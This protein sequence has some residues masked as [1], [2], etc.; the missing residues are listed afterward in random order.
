LELYTSKIDL[1]TC[2]ARWL[3]ARKTNGIRPMHSRWLGTLKI[4]G[5]AAWLKNYPLYVSVYVSR[6]WPRTPSSRRW[7]GDP[8][9]AYSTPRPLRPRGSNVRLAWST[10]TP[11]DHGHCQ[12]CTKIPLSRGNPHNSQPVGERLC[13][14]AGVAYFDSGQKVRIKHKESICGKNQNCIHC[15]VFRDRITSTEIPYLDEILITVTCRPEIVHWDR[16]STL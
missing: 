1:T 6:G 13:T 2:K 10:V 3:K 15:T 8:P 4:T 5:S 14:G 11:L 9:H 7:E 16:P 12:K